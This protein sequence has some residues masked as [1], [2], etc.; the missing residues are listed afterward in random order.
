M[1][2]PTKDYVTK[3]IEK[4]NAEKKALNS[5]QV[6][7]MNA[8][9]ARVE[10]YKNELVEGIISRYSNLLATKDIE[11]QNTKRMLEELK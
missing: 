3:H 7:E 11:I 6:E 5:K 8:V 9:N 1:S 10:T 2:D 4:L